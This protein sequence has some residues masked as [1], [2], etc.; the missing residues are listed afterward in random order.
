MI[1]FIL[2]INIVATDT[3]ALLELALQP[4]PDKL[5]TL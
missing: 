5:V 1:F 3:T 4:S 2:M